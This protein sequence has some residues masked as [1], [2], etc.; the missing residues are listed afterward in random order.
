M[1]SCHKYQIMNLQQ[2]KFIDLHQDISHTPQDNLSNDLL[3]PYNTTSQGN[4]YVLTE[5]CNLTGYIMT[6]QIRDKK[7]TSVANHLFVDIMLKFSFPRILHLDNGAEFKSKLVENLSQ[8]L[9]T[10]KTFI[11]PCHPQTNGKLKYP[12]G[13][14][15]DCV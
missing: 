10:S 15:K 1:S 3:G 14:I 13:F 7:T 9:G 4:I 12:H 8:Q 6:T 5:V 2:P 11:Y